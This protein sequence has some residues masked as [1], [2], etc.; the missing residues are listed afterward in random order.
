MEVRSCRLW[1]THLS[2]HAR[3]QNRV[4]AIFQ[5]LHIQYSTKTVLK[6]VLQCPVMYTSFQT[7]LCALKLCNRIYDC[8]LSLPKFWFLNVALFYCGFI[9][10]FCWN[11]A[12]LGKVHLWSIINAVV[13]HF[14]PGPLNVSGRYVGDHS[15]VFDLCYFAQAKRWQQWITCRL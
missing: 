14:P 15:L 4:L 5:I 11:P 2:R 7:C 12:F 3:E 8:F 1:R 10:S 13:V 6:D 9:S